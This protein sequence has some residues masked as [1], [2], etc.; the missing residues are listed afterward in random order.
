MIEFKVELSESAAKI[1]ALLDEKK[2]SF[3]DEGTG[4]IDAGVYIEAA[5]KVAGIKKETLE[6]VRQFDEAFAAGAFASF[7]QQSV[8]WFIE[9][10]ENK[11][12]KIVV[13]MTGADKAVVSFNRT[14]TTMDKETREPV[15]G[16]GD[17]LFAYHY[18][19]GSIEDSDFAK[20]V[21]SVKDYATAALK[22]L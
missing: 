12:T 22:D 7:G 14:T 5:E 9:K 21:Q 3:N 6:Q 18:S 1:K 10:P 2:V 11:Q 8:D 17:G 19:S 4:D 15:I 20:A 13:P 16:F